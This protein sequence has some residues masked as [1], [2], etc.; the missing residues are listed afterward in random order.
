MK[1]LLFVIESLRA[2]G[3]EKSLITLL[4]SLDY[5]RFDVDLQLFFFSGEFIPY[6]PEQVRILPS[7]NYLTNWHS[8][9]GISYI[10]SRV[11]YSVTIRFAKSNKAKARWYWR[12]FSRYIEK[13][14]NSYD[15]AIGYGQCLPTFYVVDK[16]YAN[17]KLGWVNCIYHL[18][19]YERRYQRR[20]YEA[21][22]KIIMVSEQSL[23][24]FAQ[25]YPEF[26]KRMYMLPD[27]I[28]PVTIVEMSR[29]G[30]SFDDG[31]QGSRIITVARLN[32]NDKG[33]DITLEACRCLK[34]RGFIFRWYAIG[35]GE[36]KDA[37]LRFIRENHLEDTFI[38]LGTTPNPYKY[39]SE[40][41]VY[42]Q[43]SRHEGFGLSLAEARI[44]NI[45]VVTTEFDSVYAQMVPYKNGLV[46][47]QDPVAVTDAI[48]RLLTDK[49]L[50]NSIVA[51]LK[52]EKKGNLEV[53]EDF[54][55]IIDS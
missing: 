19:G 38:L 39:I 16:V 53:I 17:L 22:N 28:N 51:Y 26:V 18:S 37:I 10:V 41:D 15:V 44:L 33:Y 30:Q 52:N 36:Y 40:A 12:Y 54:Y 42:V 32:R 25:V 55:K 35:R 23:S 47:P 4:S 45:P 5:E 24:H 46:V 1:K 14:N 50:H 2:A 48:Q 3:G 21:L 27:I 8:G 43:T 31:F 7:F 13:S 6:V 49:S 34:Q 9:L 29:K 11:L 20:F